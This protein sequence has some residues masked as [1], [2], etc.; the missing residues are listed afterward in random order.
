MF[1]IKI[2]QGLGITHAL[3]KLVEET[4]DA[5][6][7]DNNFTVKEWNDTMD[8]LVEI[9]QQRIANGQESIFEGNTD[10]TKDGWK[11]SFV[12]KTG[13]EIEFSKEEMDQLYDAM[14]V[15]F[16]KKEKIE[17]ISGVNTLSVEPVKIS[18]SKTTGGLMKPEEIQ[19]IINKANQTLSNMASSKDEH[20]EIE[21]RSHPSNKEQ[22]YRT[23]HVNG[24]N[25]VDITVADK[26]ITGISIGEKSENKYGNSV[27]YKKGKD[28][29]V[30]LEVSARNADNVLNQNISP[31]EESDYYNIEE[32][33]RVLFE[34]VLKTDSDT[35]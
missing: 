11:N 30:T 14:G 24:K 15:S 4:P 3:K 12:V 7:S 10:K 20:G 23:E 28:G 9:N 31:I 18:I 19:P 21:H 8:K 16:R 22:K 26:E 27:T 29:E 32:Q 25:Y 17:K 34:D 13:Q 1:R 6:I 35:E 33:A 5:I 2:E